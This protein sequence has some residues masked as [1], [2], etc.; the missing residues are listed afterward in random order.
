MA[1]H[2]R[3]EFPHFLLCFGK[4]CVVSVFFF[5]CLS[6][7]IKFYSIVEIATLLS[8][9][10][11]FFLIFVQKQCWQCQNFML[12]SGGK[13]EMKMSVWVQNQHVVTTFP[14]N[15]IDYILQWFFV[16][17]YKVVKFAGMY[18]TIDYNGY[19]CHYFIY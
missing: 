13:Q 6:M 14:L 18:K 16:G 7:V 12:V 9:R 15:S 2:C 4:Q 19:S 17:K 8:L 3:K 10:I 1:D 5:I 11:L